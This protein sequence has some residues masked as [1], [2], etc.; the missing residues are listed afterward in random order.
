[1]SQQRKLVVA[2]AA[3]FGFEGGAVFPD[4]LQYRRELLK[5]FLECA[6]E[7]HQVIRVYEIGLL[8]ECHDDG[9][10]HPPKR[11]KRRAKY[12]RHYLELVEGSQSDEGRLLSVAFVDIDLPVVTP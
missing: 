7:S 4:S 9:I 5:M 10:H 8:L 2:E 12:K 6:K 1:M 11:F 3:L